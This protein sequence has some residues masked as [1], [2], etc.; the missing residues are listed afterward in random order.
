MP[1]KLTLRLDAALINR[2]KT[3]AHEQDRSL[4]QLVADY[5]THLTVKPAAAGKTL[6]EHGAITWLLC[7]TTITTLAYLAGKQWIDRRPP[8]ISGDC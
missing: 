1:T 8:C 5:F 2:A 4:S 7:A 3:Y 6:V